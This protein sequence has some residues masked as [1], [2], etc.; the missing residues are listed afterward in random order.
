MIVPTRACV[1]AILALIAAGPA[2]AQEDPLARHAGKPI[3]AVRMFVEGEPVTDP[4]LLALVDLAAGQT[5]SV[6][7]LRAN[8]Q[9]LRTLP[10]YEDVLVT[11]DDAPGGLVIA[12]RLEPRHP[13][14]RLEFRGRPDTGVPVA[15]LEARIREAFGG[16]PA[17]DRLEDVEQAV[18]DVLE[19]EGFRSA[20]VTVSR[21]V[22][23]E[24]DR[25]TLVFTIEPG[26]RTTIASVQVNGESPYGVQDILK[27]T[28][29]A[30]GA[31]YR[32]RQIETELV[33]LRD[34]LSAKGFYAAVAQQIPEFKGDTVGLTLVV[35]AGPVVT[36]RVEPADALP[37][38][39]ETYI[40]I[41]RE[42]S[43]DRD[44]LEDSQT[45]IQRALQRQGYADAEV[46]FTT[47][48]PTPDRLIIT[49]TIARGPRVRVER[50]ESPTG[51]HLPPADVVTLLGIEPGDVL[52]PTELRNGEARIAQR[53]QQLGFHQAKVAAVRQ[54][55]LERSSPREIRTA[56][57]FQIEEGPQAFIRAITFELGPEPAVATSAL[58]PVMTSRLG[59]PYVYA[60]LRSDVLAVAQ[61]Y[62]RRGYGEAVVEIV[63]QISEDGREAALTVRVK[64]GPRRIVGDII[65]V[66]NDRI[67]TDR[68]LQDL[69]LTRGQPWSDE[70]RFESRRRLM[71]TGGYRNVTITADQAVAGESAV[72]VIVAVEEAPA[73]SL[74]VGGGL[75]AGNRAR[76]TPEGSFDDQ[77]EVA[78]RAFFEITR[79]NLGGRNR[80]LN[81]FSRLSLKSSSTDDPTDDG[82]VFGFTE[83]RVAATF[84]E[85]N[86]FRRDTEL[87]LG[88]AS[89]QAVRTSF[90]FIRHSA[91]AEL[92]HR[93]SPNVNVS[94]RY[95]LEFNRLFDERFLG[96]D[97]E[98]S[99]IDR[100]FPEVRL[101]FLSGGLFWDRRDSVLAP[102]TGTLFV[103]DHEI[104][105]RQIG[106]EVGFVKSF[107]Q[108][109]YFRPLTAN[110][111][112]VLATRAQVGAARGFERTVPDLDE[113]GAPRI[114][115]DGEP[116]TRVITDLPASHRFFAGGS[117]T[118]RGFQLDRLGDLRVLDADG[119]SNGGVLNSSGL[120]SGGNGLILM[121]AEVR[122]V[123]GRLFGRG[124]GVAGFVDGGNVFDRVSAM[125]LARLRGAVGFGV[126]Y[127]SPLGPIRLDFGFKMNRLTFVGR[128]ERGWEYHLSIGEAF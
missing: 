57:Q 71:Q 6:A 11:V 17:G 69:T 56:I 65:V 86:A 104:A 91:N 77:L 42:G 78:P 61:E 100:V 26:P 118:V 54:D 98:Q 24:P 87:L 113:T 108:L 101:S 36:L 23:H 72:R 67:G 18:R 31:P 9:R 115:S 90:N 46:R 94:G 49:F 43:V 117:T 3:A 126:R 64:A 99:L 92:L 44:L 29:V 7:A 107:Y 79:R 25:A 39:V 63:P 76:S 123:V 38:D 110:R 106:S 85:Q 58:Q 68:I 53:Y 96:D 116:L 128:R 45:M 34:E 47:E 95:A 41:K 81:W 21:E 52:I 8:E 59:D 114:G 119:E 13:V 37:G 103:A 33:A 83:Y 125:S 22:R 102:T 122:A 5:F 73:T 55:L 19:E 70:V 74:G 66:G 112:F 124:F 109:S 35:D 12:F 15:E 28:G 30:V 4:S 97:E 121:N 89:E 32:E 14:D 111:R 120:S 27:R 50:V 93:F 82:R 88:V 16:L 62:D 40:P 20:A 2:A 1:V 48:R 80:S 84:R 10:H 51:L 127:D 75:E 105:L 60:T